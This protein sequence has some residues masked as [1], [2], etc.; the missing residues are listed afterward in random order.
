M[1]IDDLYIEGISIPPRKTYPPLIIDAN[2][3]LTGTIAS[4]RLQAVAG[5]DS[6]EIKAGGSTEQFQFTLSQALH[7]LR[8]FG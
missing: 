6:Q 8:E 7:I 4:K 5:R 1:I 2:T 3:P